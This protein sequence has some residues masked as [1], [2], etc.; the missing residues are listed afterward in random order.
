MKAR[1]RKQPLTWREIR[2]NTAWEVGELERRGIDP[3]VYA[4]QRQPDGSAQRSRSNTTFEA[5]EFWATYPD[6]KRWHCLSCVTA[7]ALHKFVA[8]LHYFCQGKAHLW[9][10]VA[11]LG[12]ACLVSESGMRAQ[13]IMESV[14]RFFENSSYDVEH[15]ASR[16]HFKH[17]SGL[18]EKAR[19]HVHTHFLFICNL[20][21]AKHAKFENAFYR[22][23][24]GPGNIIEP[25]KDRRRITSY[26]FQTPDT[27]PLLGA[28]CY[29]DWAI[30]TRGLRLYS[31]Y[32]SFKAQRKLLKE[33]GKRVRRVRSR[34]REI[35]VLEQLPPP[36]RR[37]RVANS[38][39]KIVEPNTIVG[40]TEIRTRGGRTPATVIKNAQCRRRSQT[41]AY[42]LSIP[43]QYRSLNPLFFL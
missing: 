26:I 42:A 14:R 39:P 3:H 35:Y 4:L 41:T 16:I 43:R 21:D 30:A 40:E 22:R 17:C 31:A 12:P 8:G 29:V 9:C 20:D 7:K 25:A 10:G 23:F 28:G 2:E 24:K 33:Q 5:P 36:R 38:G 27:R 1:H 6:Y 18:S 19:I 32:S 13:K 37:P 34:L 15:I 11:N